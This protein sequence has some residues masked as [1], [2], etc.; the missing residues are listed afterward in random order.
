MT[1]PG[2]LTEQDVVAVRES[3]AAGKPVT[4][5]FT[6]AA[7]GVP[8]GR[9]AKVSAVGDASEGDFI[10]VK[11]AGSRDTM[12]CSPNELTLT[13]PARRSATAPAATGKAATGKAAT[14]KAAT[15]K[16]ATGKA[17][18]VAAAAGPGPATRAAA[19]DG[20]PVRP[21]AARGATPGAGASTSTPRPAAGS[22]PA[23]STAA[24]PTAGAPTAGAA[25]S[26]A[27]TA[28]AATA[29]AATAGEAT[30]T[31][32]SGP[33]G[34]APAASG[35]A[36]S[37]ADLARAGTPVPTTR[38]ARV[39]AARPSGMTVTLEATP[40][41]EWSVEV[42]VGTKRVVPAVPVP[43]ADLATAARS[44]PPAVAEAIESSLEGARQRQR[45]R[46]EQLRSELDAAQRVLDQLDV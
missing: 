31:G 27:V 12:F 34:S 26:T 6:E 39:R 10:Q 44:L 40:E 21:A 45:D 42:R 8:A 17:T 1:A 23:T 32:R 43:A 2:A 33:A 15:G 11:P 35:R 16:A 25:T 3:A 29:G 41:G 24:T 28:G 19:P 37:A 22:G 7:V 30:S 36:G 5:W 14:G 13:R 9:S 4:V 38:P 18:A 46:V 20:A